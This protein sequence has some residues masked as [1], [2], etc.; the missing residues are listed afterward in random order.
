[1]SEPNDATPERPRIIAILNCHAPN[2]ANRGQVLVR[3]DGSAEIFPDSDRSLIKPAL[4]ALRSIDLRS[5][6]GL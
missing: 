4:A 6:R 2:G 3:A 1:M 5:F